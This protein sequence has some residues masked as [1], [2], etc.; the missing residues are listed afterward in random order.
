MTSFG[1]HPQHIAKIGVS[2]ARGYGGGQGRNRT[3]D[4]SLFRVVVCHSHPPDL[5][6][7]AAIFLALPC[8]FIGT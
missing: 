4:A 1:T 2:T 3:V 6:L 8:P 7:V 5:I